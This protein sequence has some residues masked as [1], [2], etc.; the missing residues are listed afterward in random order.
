MIK[1]LKK[2]E[3]PLYS[4]CGYKIGDTIK[5]QYNCYEIVGLDIPDSKDNERDGTCRIL[6]AETDV[7]RSSCTIDD[8]RCDGYTIV[9]K[10]GARKAKYDVW[11]EDTEISK[12]ED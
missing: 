8:L 12:I 7:M 5:W 10:K 3:Y 6:L 4:I 11:V 2:K 1:R 9:Y